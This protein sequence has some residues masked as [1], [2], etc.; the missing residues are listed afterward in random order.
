M[1]KFVADSSVSPTGLKWAAP[2]AGGKVLQVVSSTTTTPVTIATTTLTD[3]G[4]TA[5]ITPTLSTSKVLIL[6]TYCIDFNVSGVRDMEGKGRLLRGGTTLQDYVN[7]FFGS[8]QTVAY[9]VGSYILE[10][11]NSIHYLDSPATTSATTYKLQ[12][13]PEN[14]VSGRSYRFQTSDGPSNITLFEIGA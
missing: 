5:T 13:A 12:A 11:Q 14:T 7:N 3:T 6:I 9:S 10:G 8:Q 2:A 4:I 1:P